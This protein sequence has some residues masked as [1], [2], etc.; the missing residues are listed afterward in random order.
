[1]HLADPA[2]FVATAC[3]PQLFAMTV[4]MTSE[5]DMVTLQKELCMAAANNSHLVQQ[6][7]ALVDLKAYWKSVSIHCD[8]F[9]WTM[10][11]FVNTT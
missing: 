6:L 9:I 8:I 10:I 2:Q 5:I 1:M 3:D 11:K 4:N 7:I